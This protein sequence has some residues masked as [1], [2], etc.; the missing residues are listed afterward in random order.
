MDVLIVP[1]GLSPDYYFFLRTTAKVNGTEVVIDRRRGERRTHS[2]IVD[3]ERRRVD[4]RGPVPV[5]WSKGEFI[6]LQR[7]T[8]S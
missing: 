5:T 8:G 7:D 2:N 1:R 4:R 3:A 6:A